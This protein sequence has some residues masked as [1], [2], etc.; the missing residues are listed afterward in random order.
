[1][2][3]NLLD[4]E[5]E[6]GYSGESIYIIQYPKEILSVSYGIL[7]SIE[8]LNRNDFTHSCSTEKGSS[9]SPILN[10]KNNKL[11]GI[12]KK[13]GGASN[14]NIGVFLKDSIKEFIKKECK[15]IDELNK[16]YNLNIK[17]SRITELDLPKVKIGNEGLELIS[18][19]EFME[20][21]KLILEKNDISNIE[22][23]KDL[24]CCLVSYS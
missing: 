12:H 2:D 19:I 15:L 8:E 24:K 4:D 22:A 11:V 6:E 13:S 9:G 1:M 10:S 3:E 20:L 23:L 17:S 7:I 21:K 5:S 14:C 18:K 16:K